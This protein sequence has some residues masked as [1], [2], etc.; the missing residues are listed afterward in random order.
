V[1]A[2]GGLRLNE[3]EQLGN[4]SLVIGRCSVQIGSKARPE[5]PSLQGL[6]G[7]GDDGIRTHFDLKIRLGHRPAR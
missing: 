4:K 2:S 1:K 3:K 5:R 6:Q 7:R